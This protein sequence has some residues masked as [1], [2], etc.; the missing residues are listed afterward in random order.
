MPYTYSNPCQVAYSFG[1]YNFT[2]ATTRRVTAPPRMNAATVIDVQVHATTT[3]TATT[4]PGYVNVGVAT[5]DITAAGTAAGKTQ[6]LTQ[7]AS[8]PMG[9]TAAGTPLSL[10]TLV[11]PITRTG[12]LQYV[13]SDIEFNRDLIQSVTISIVAPTGGSPAG[14]GWTDVI[15]GWF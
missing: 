14:A 4:T 3:F 15:I 5:A 7:F 8:V 2:T 13:F 9:T 6:N 1:N 12:L 11:N 10:A